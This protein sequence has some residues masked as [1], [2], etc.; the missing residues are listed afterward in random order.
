M[1]YVPNS[2]THPPTAEVSVEVSE[3]TPIEEKIISPV[4]PTP[5]AVQLLLSPKQ[6]ADER[7]DGTQTF[8]G[9]GGAILKQ[10]DNSRIQSR[11]PSRPS[12]PPTDLGP[13]PVVGIGGKVSKPDYSELKIVVAMVGLPARGKSYLSNKLTRYL[14][15]FNVGQLRRSK[16]RAKK[17]KF[18]FSKFLHHASKLIGC[19]RSGITED[20]TASY[21]SH[22][23][24]KAS[25]LREALAEEC[26]ESLISWLKKGGN[27]AIHDA[28]NSTEA[29]REKIAARVA[30]DPDLVVLFLESYCDDPA[31]IAANIALKV[32]AGD[33][34]YAHMSREDAERDF[35]NR[36]K[37]YEAVY[38]TVTE[39]HL[40]YVKIIN[41]G[42]QVQMNRIHGY[43]QSRIVFYLMNLHL[44]PRSIFMSR[45][46]TSTLQRTIE[47]A[48]QLSYPKLTWKSLD[49]LDAGVC[50]G[51]TYEEIEA[52]YPEDFE[53]RDDDKFNYRYRGGESYRDVVVRLEPVIME[54]E[55]QDNV[56]VIGH[57]A[58]IRC[59]WVI[60]L[61]TSTTAHEKDPSRYA[62]FTNLSQEELPYINIPLHTVI[63]LTPKAYGCD[64]ERYT[65]PVGAVSTHRPKPKAS[66]AKAKAKSHSKPAQ[67]SVK[68]D[69]Y[70]NFQT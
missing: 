57:Q 62:Y 51:M 17:E 5:D 66:E 2:H 22:S 20:H 64:E 3:A 68:R 63:K 40:S 58:I 29:R 16:A 61:T 69:Y 7:P 38:Q 67:A 42:N 48:A 10:F 50:D 47:T 56:L 37:Q 70:G 21:F 19:V 33:P 46:W 34:D 52:A 28:T 60:Y 43:V 25:Q 14:R 18:V 23:D 12:S 41:V 31:V 45:V 30:K 26:L 6:V 13:P 59:L 55:R 24:D 15:V 8:F 35:R 39:P 27:V 49:E 44:K 32:S 4:E 53:A 36:I 65:L 1:A 11:R 9:A 54:L